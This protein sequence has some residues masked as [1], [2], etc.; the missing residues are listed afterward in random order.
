MA[1][2]ERAR[3]GTGETGDG[4]GGRVRQGSGIIAMSAAAKKLANEFIGAAR[5]NPAGRGDIF[6][7]AAYTFMGLAQN[8]KNSRLSGSLS[9]IGLEF[10]NAA[11]RERPPTMD[12]FKDL[13]LETQQAYNEVG[14]DPQDL[15]ARRREIHDERTP[16]T[17]GFVSIA[18]ESFNRDA[19]LGRSAK[20]KFAP[21]PEE[22]H[23]GILQNVNV[24][25][26]QGTKKE[27]QAMTV[28]ASLGFLPAPPFGLDTPGGIFLDARPFGEVE[29]GSD[30]NRT[31]VKFDL[32]FGKRLTVVGNYIAVTV[33]MDPPRPTFACPT[34]TAGAS[35]GAFAAPSPAPLVLTAYVDGIAAGTSSKFIPIPLKAVELL[36]LQSNMILGDT[37]TISFFNYGGA[38]I[39]QVFY[40]QSE[41]TWIQPIPI[42]GDVAFIQ[43]ANT[44]AHGANYRFPFQLAM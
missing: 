33:G 11:S 27:A 25:F 2:S 42:T 35:I 43:I 38:F 20:I 30:G 5:V 28:D 37:A 13:L 19:T 6:R 39:S 9:K 21:T 7:E 36:P 26:W 24:A 17:P 31:K 16:H 32:A 8:P 10:A 29:Y 34:L 18:P 40:K 44:S 22:V 41:T 4:R 14:D 1:E 12:D 15:V 23:D 3:S